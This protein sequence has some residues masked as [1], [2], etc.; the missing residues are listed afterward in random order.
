[1]KIKIFK[2][3]FFLFITII[4]LTS[5]AI[6]IDD[7]HY[8]FCVM[9]DAVITDYAAKSAASTD[10]LP[11]L[12]DAVWYS[13]NGVKIN[14]KDRRIE[15]GNGV[16]NVT[17]LMTELFNG[18]P[19]FYGAK[20][21]IW[22]N[23][24]KGINGYGYSQD[25]YIYIYVDAPSGVELSNIPTRML[26]GDE[27]SIKSKLTGSYTAFSGNGYFDYIYSS[28]DTE[29]A[30]ISSGKIIANK[31]GKVTITVSAYAKNKKYSGSYYI[32]TATADIEI[33][34]N[35][36]PIN[37]S[38]NCQDITLDV[39][40]NTSISATLTPEDAR[41]TITWTSSNPHVATIE[42]GLIKAI[43]SG[44]TIIEAHT[45]NGLTAKCNVTVL[46][47]EDYKHVFINELYYNLDKDNYTATV[48]PKTD[49][50]GNIENGY[51]SGVIIIPENVNFFGTNYLVTGIGEY[52]FYNCNLTSI[53]LPQ[54]ILT[55]DNY[56]FAGTTIRDIELPD[57]LNKIGDFSFSESKI[58]SMLI[59]ANLSEIGIGAFKNCKNLQ[60]IY[61]DENN[62]NF[63][64]HDDCLYNR[65][66]EELS[67]IPLDK[68]KITF[69]DKLKTIL[70]YACAN[71]K[72]I[73]NLIFPNNLTSINEGA[74][75]GCNNLNTLNFPKSLQ[76]IE[77]M[78]FYECNELEEISIENNISIIG[79]NAFTSENLNK[80]K[81]N[82]LKP[83]TVDETS[84]KNYNA[85]LVV[86]KGRIS[87]YEKHSIWGNFSNIIDNEDNTSNITALGIKIDD[88]N[89][90]WGMNR[91]QVVSCQTGEYN[92]IQDNTSSIIFSKKINNEID[93]CISYKFD[94]NKL[95]ASIISFP[96]NTETKNFS[97]EI[98]SQYNAE[99][100]VKS[101][102]EIKKIENNI[103]SIDNTSSINDLNIIT[104]GFSYY[105]P[106]EERDDCVDL[107]LSVRWG[108]MNLGSTKSSE[109]GNFY[110]WSETTSKTE[111][112]RENYAYCNNNSNQYVFN[113]T[114]PTTNICGTQ[115]D[116]TT[117]VLGDGWKMPSLAEANEL[118]TLCTWEKETID[119]VQVYRVTGP[120]GNSIILPIIGFKRQDKSHSTTILYL[121]T[122]ECSTTDSDSFY[123]IKNGVIGNEWKA[124]GYNIRP[125]YTK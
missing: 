100:S 16:T 55:I 1:M 29:I 58:E 10:Q 66:L 95:C 40:E 27:I 96:E 41:T 78:C 94:N 113:Y 119:G 90:T 34:D 117:K 114:N 52:A 51:I 70:A 111:Y 103:I 98:F 86:P 123:V 91:E 25:T 12:S 121:A 64:I 37:I 14:G 15:I 118:I 17:V 53:T 28:S 21:C 13:Y 107:G 63:L 93:I 47:D 80:I 62:Q 120:N 71:N 102:M 72:V 5:K 125:V 85:T 6:K 18:I 124:W 83:P 104:I 36:D 39:G 88:V 105:E 109:V 20:H 84:F 99:I 4:P 31:T 74:F 24:Y 8:R 122:G 89:R 101:G 92:L 50:N 23:W 30:S 73:T 106:F 43:E 115:Y 2:I 69:S 68:D 44:N 32:G 38:L 79:K 11:V 56:G 116:A 112:W 65:T 97:D 26:I 81:L 22:H 3:L 59:G 54:S 108:T 76:S 49:S 82:T 75:Y 77:D 7:T 57:K 110:A 9:D 61:I 67:Y 35:M 19:S 48:I 60:A 42:D 46:D 87:V 45:S 33:V